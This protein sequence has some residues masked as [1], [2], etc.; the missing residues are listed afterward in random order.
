MVSEAR[1][2][3]FSLISVECAYAVDSPFTARRPKP[4]EASKLAD[5]SRWSS[6]TSD[7]DRFSSRN[8]SPSSA[9]LSTSAKNSLVLSWS[10]YC[11]NGRNFSFFIF[12][13]KF[14]IKIYEND[15]KRL[16]DASF[17]LYLSARIW[18]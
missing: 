4:F 6:K 8:N 5:F 13:P 1:F 7:S 16:F 10:K 14:F 15:R 17:L 2:N 3:A 11:S 12:L 18:F 9:G